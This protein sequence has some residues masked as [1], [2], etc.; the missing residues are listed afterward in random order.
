MNENRQK[1]Y[2]YA[3]SEMKK[4]IGKPLTHDTIMAIHKLVIGPSGNHN[5]RT[6]PCIVTNRATHDSY[7]PPEDPMY[8]V[9]DLTTELLPW[10][11]QTPDVVEQ[12]ARLH[13]G[14]VKIHPFD[15]GNGRTARLLVYL[16]LLN[17]G[18]DE[19]TCQK[20]EEYFAK[21]D[22]KTYDRSL[23]DGRTYTDFKDISPV[24]IGYLKKGVL[25]S[26]MS[27]KREN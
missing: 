15:G 1:N 21:D 26:S 2:V 6:R 25:N 14:F 20:L 24:F 23:D 5:Y 4:R 18:Y 19:V 11:D 9:E 7:R 16:V 17:H 13:W 12:A 3:Y 22:W 10:H 8:S 27:T